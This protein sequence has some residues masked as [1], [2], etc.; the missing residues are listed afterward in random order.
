VVA[1]AAAAAGLA[2]GSTV[3]LGILVA[4]TGALWLAATV[5]HAV[6]APPGSPR[7]RDTH[8]VIR[9]EQAARH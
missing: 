8:E 1:L 2:G 6:T 9:A 3:A 4:A 7:S 5:R